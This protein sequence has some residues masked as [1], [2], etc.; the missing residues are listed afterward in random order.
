M[1]TVTDKQI[2]QAIATIIDGVQPNAKIYPRWMQSFEE[3]E[4]VALL[5]S[6]DDSDRVNCWMISRVRRDEDLA[7]EPVDLTWS[8]A[9]NFYFQ[10]E[11]GYDSQN[12]EDALD[13]HLEAV[14]KAI[15]DKPDLNLGH[16]DIREHGGLQFTAIGVVAFGETL[17]H[18]AQGELDVFLRDLEQSNEESD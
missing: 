7:A 12:S 10:Y 14:T 13:T 11:F 15:R 9:V 17:V 8:Y 5:R 3:G 4:F 2:R 16:V 18:I 6:A 1:P